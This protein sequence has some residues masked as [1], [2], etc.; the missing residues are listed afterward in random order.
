MP[1]RAPH[2]VGT[3]SSYRIDA[4]IGQILT[5]FYRRCGAWQQEEVRHVKR[6]EYGVHIFDCIDT[7]VFGAGEKPVGPSRFALL[8]R[9]RYFISM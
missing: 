7:P 8:R 6:L 5:F 2:L 3:A 9:P 1:K 4:L